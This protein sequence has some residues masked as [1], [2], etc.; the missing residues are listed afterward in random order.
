M[1]SHELLKEVLQ[2]ISAKQVSSE[3]G[4]SLSL[5]Y[6]WAEPA[7]E[8][9]GAANPLDRI[10]QLL[11]LSGDRRLA[12]WVCERAGGFF[13]ANPKTNPQAVHLIP[14]TNMIVEEFA[15][16]LAVIARAATDNTI[17]KKEANDIR[18]R[19]EDLKSVTEGFVRCCEAGNFGPV[20]QHLARRAKI[21]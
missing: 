17:T 13:I 16:M 7:A 2:K 15:D 12:Q 1:Q 8:G 19:W 10:E 6:K 3:L 9:S 5:I 21:A 20:H 4:L 18:G 14:A 11:K